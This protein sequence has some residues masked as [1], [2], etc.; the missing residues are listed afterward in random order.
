MDP[1]KAAKPATQTPQEQVV[2]MAKEIGKLEAKVAQLQTEVDKYKAMCQ[3][4]SGESINMVGAGSHAG[5][6]EK[7]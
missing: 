5:S 3:K 2:S 1:K 6:Q 4:N 7:T